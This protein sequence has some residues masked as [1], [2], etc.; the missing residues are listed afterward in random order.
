MKSKIWFG[1]LAAALLLS[2]C[3]GSQT[4]IP[5]TPQIARIEP[6]ATLEVLPQPNTPPASPTPLPVA[7][8]TESDTLPPVPS[9]CTVVSSQYSPEPTQQ[10]IFPPVSSTDWIIGPDTAVVTLVEYGDFQ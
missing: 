8:Q 7:T 1:L 10:S 9:G 4:E 6:T 5:I 3:A 2:A